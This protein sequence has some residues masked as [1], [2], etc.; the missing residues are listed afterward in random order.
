MAFPALA[1]E[2]DGMLADLRFEEHAVLKAE[3]DGAFVDYPAFL[4]VLRAVSGLLSSR[5]HREGGG[6]PVSA[7]RECA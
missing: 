6:K 7:I 2:L 3:G 4:S 1:D 5:P